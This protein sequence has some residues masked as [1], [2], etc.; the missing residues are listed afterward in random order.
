MKKHLILSAIL[1][2][3]TAAGMAQQIPLG[4][5]GFVYLHDAAGGRTKML[6]FCNNGIDPYPSRVNGNPQ[7]HPEITSAELKTMEFQEVTA[8]YPNPTTGRFSVT[9][10][11]SVSAASVSITDV[12]GKTVQQVKASGVKVDFDISSLSAGVYYVRVE[13]NGRVIAK[14]VIKQ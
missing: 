3:F 10:S 2:L 1:V 8:L 4:S 13:E 9:F 6:Y 5:C 7:A 12:N 14:K 11:V